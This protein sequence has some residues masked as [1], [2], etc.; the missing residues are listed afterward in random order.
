MANNDAHTQGMS[1]ASNLK[2]RVRVVNFNEAVIQSPLILSARVRVTK[3]WRGAISRLT[4]C[5]A[6][7]F[8]HYAPNSLRHHLLS[9]LIFAS[10]NINNELKNIQIGF[11]FQGEYFARLNE[12]KL[13]CSVPYLAA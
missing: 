10:K 6:L 7:C 2:R 13:A 5:G 12:K 1:S 8:K 3:W 11:R 9:S 4:M